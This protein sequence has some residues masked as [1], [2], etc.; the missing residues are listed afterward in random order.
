MKKADLLYGRDAGGTLTSRRTRRRRWRRG[1]KWP[2]S[3]PSVSSTTTSVS[4]PTP[5]SRWSSTSPEVGFKLAA[6][7]LPLLLSVSLQP[8][9]YT[10]D[11]YCHLISVL[12]FFAV[13]IFHDTVRDTN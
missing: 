9:M 13:L 10:G 8:V 6:G 2:R 5:M 3:Y 4:G 1:R 12:G 11:R 7:W